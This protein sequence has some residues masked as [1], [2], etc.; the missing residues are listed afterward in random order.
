MFWLSDEIARAIRQTIPPPGDINWSDLRIPFDSGVFM[1]PK[2]S[3]TH[4]IDGDVHFVA[5]ARLQAGKEFISPL[6]G[7]PYFVENGVMIFLANAGPH[8]F[9]WILPLDGKPALSLV[10]LDDML[11]SAGQDY[12]GGHP[13]SEQARRLSDPDKHLGTGVAHYILGTIL[14]MNARPELV[15]NSTMQK[16]VM[17]K[18]VI[19]KEFW[20]PNIIGEHYKVRREVV[21][22]GGNHASPR[23]HW[24]R[25]SY[26][27]QPYGAGSELRKQIW[28]EPFMR[29]LM[30]Q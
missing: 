3:L 22:H 17:K 30:P 10:E 14:L 27:Q 13:L 23:F 6:C 1:L 11:M 20:T 24:V 9:H 16:R 19:P 18:G 29:G 15:T 25:G 28:V 12:G 7:K 2:G 26:R 21:D 4:P 5:Y 8:F